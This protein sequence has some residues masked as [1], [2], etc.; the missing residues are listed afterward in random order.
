VA[1]EAFLAERVRFAA[2]AEIVE[3]TLAALPPTVPGHFEDLYGADAEA[4][5][6]A[7]GLVEATGART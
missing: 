2:I 1:V 3:D 5:E 7:R 4:R 6:H